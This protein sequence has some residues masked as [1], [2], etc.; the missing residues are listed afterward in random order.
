M[1][2][3]DAQRDNGSQK[4][5]HNLSEDGPSGA[6]NISARND[7]QQKLKPA[8]TCGSGESPAARLRRGAKV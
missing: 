7:E 4:L 2:W 5:R 8:I 6:S 1:R 3:R